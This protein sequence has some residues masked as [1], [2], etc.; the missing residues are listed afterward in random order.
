M[1][2]TIKESELKISLHWIPGHRDIDGNEEADKIAKQAS[3]AE[4]ENM[5]DTMK[6][7]NIV[8]AEIYEECWK[9]WIKRWEEERSPSYFSQDLP[10]PTHVAKIKKDLSIAEI[11]ILSQFRCGRIENGYSLA[12]SL[13][14]SLPNRTCKCG[15]PETVK[16]IL[17][18]CWI[19]HD[20]RKKLKGSIFKLT[21][22]RRLNLKII[23]DN[24]KTSILTAR[25]L[26]SVVSR[27]KSL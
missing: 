5:I 12:G 23:L 24:V 14:S 4:S 7:M 21:G 6:S 26:L 22:Y 25:F 11:S 19:Y 17:L 2:K 18:Y 13:N 9:R 8:K 3:K 20:I 16:H 27:R 15:A 1:C 10:T